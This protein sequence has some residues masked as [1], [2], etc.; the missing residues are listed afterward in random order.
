MADLVTLDMLRK[1]AEKQK[2]RSEN[3]VTTEKKLA[4]IGNFL[5]DD[6]TSMLDISDVYPGK[7]ASQV[8]GAFRTV[9]KDND[10][11]ELVWP[12]DDGQ[13]TTYLV[14]LAGESA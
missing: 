12:T 10:L 9:I 1:R 4:I 6:E 3:R 14:K 2:A 7:P 8:I 5:D 11:S 13:G